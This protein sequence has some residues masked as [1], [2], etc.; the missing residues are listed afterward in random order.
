MPSARTS[1]WNRIPRRAR[2][3]ELAAAI[4]FHH[5]TDGVRAGGN[6]DAVADLDVARDLRRPP[7]LRRAPY[8]STAGFRLQADHRVGGDDDAL[9]TSSAADQLRGSAL[10][11][12]RSSVRDAALLSGMFDAELGD[13]DDALDGQ[14]LDRAPDRGARRWFARGS[15]IEGVV[16]ARGGA[17]GVALPHAVNCVTQPAEGPRLALEQARSLAASPTSASV[18]CTGRLAEAS[19]TGR[20]R[21]LGRLSLGGRRGWH[22]ILTR[23]RNQPPPAA[24]VMHAMPRTATAGRF[25]NMS[26]TPSTQHEQRKLRTCVRHGFQAL[27]T[28]NMTVYKV[29]STSQSVHSTRIVSWGRARY[30]VESIRVS[31]RLDWPTGCSRSGSWAGSGCLSSSRV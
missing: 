18:S 5:R 10:C 11:A 26:E 16:R 9:R 3:P 14:V 15:S 21:G 12:V 17:G 1:V 25:E 8:R 30:R 20:Q 27:S 29:S 13:C 19:A 4:H 23:H 28:W 24:A 22:R 7:C 2:S 31:G 6:R